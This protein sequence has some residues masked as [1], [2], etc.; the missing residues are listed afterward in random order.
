[1]KYPE[2]NWNENIKC[3]QDKHAEYKIKMKNHKYWN[4]F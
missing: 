2:F 1:M 4:E 3:I